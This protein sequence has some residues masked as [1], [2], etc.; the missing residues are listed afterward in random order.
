MEDEIV[1]KFEG[2]DDEDAKE[3]ILRRIGRMP[4]IEY[5][6]IDPLSG[7]VTVMGGDIDRLGIEDDIEGMG[8]PLVR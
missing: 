6:G 3:K 1:M 2:I 4:G 8:Y 5:V 7:E